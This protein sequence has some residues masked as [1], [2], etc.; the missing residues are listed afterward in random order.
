LDGK[1]TPSSR[2]HSQ[3]ASQRTN[4]TLQQWRTPLPNGQ[5]RVIVLKSI[6]GRHFDGMTGL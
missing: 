1:G 5:A 3:S 4:A 6:G 2:P